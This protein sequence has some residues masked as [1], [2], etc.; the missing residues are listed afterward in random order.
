MSDM[1]NPWDNDPVAGV[2][3]SQ[4]QIDKPWASDPVIPTSKPVN[5]QNWLSSSLNGAAEGLGGGNITRSTD[6]GALGVLSNVGRYAA[7]N[8]A[9]GLKN[10]GSAVNP[11][12]DD[13]KDQQDNNW[14]PLYVSPNALKFGKGA[15]ETIGAIPSAMGRAMLADPVANTIGVDP[16]KRAWQDSDTI[17]Q[18]AAKS[19]VDVAEAGGSMFAPTALATGLK[20][21]AR[22]IIPE[23]TPAAKALVNEGVDLTPG[24]HYP[25]NSAIRSSEDLTE[26]MPFISK[27]IKGA[28]QSSQDTFNDAVYNRALSAIGEDSI[29]TGL[30]GRDKVNYTEGKL[31]DFY[32]QLKPH[33]NYAPD[34]DLASDAG[35]ILSSKVGLSDNA[36][37]QF[38][39]IASS[40]LNRGPMGGDEFKQLDSDLGSIGLRY[41]KSQDPDQSRLGE[42][43]LDLKSSMRDNMADQNPSIAGPLSW[44]NDGYSKFMQAQKASTNRASSLGDFSPN[45]LSSVSRQENRRGFS[46]GDNDMQDLV[47]NAQS[48]LSPTIGSSGT[49]PRMQWNS[50]LDNP[51]SKVGRG[52]LA[53]PLYTGAGKQTFSDIATR[54]PLITKSLVAN[55]KYPGRG[56]RDA[57]TQEDTDK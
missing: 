5:P 41:F 33:I 12:P 35:N 24:Q 3:N 54:Q 52:M 29:P 10:M 18:K 15:L 27:L 20:G 39:D 38:S 25:S 31:N 19:L 40:V 30:N 2:D 11:S 22:G 6:T 34:V 16:N 13:L 8:V 9:T 44:A 49:A 32:D 55:P 56:L 36:K 57:V 7:N 28:K 53:S 48:Q 42:M 26:T 47:D 23:A 51:I 14:N 4:Q 17:G 46:R 50:L 21:V 37:S 45:D 1:G 43:I